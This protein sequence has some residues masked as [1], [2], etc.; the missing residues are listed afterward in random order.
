MTQPTNR[1]FRLPGAL[2]R[3][4]DATAGNPKKAVESL[5]KTVG[6]GFGSVPAAPIDTTKDLPPVP[7][8]TA[9]Q[10][11]TLMMAELNAAVRSLVESSTELAGRLGR[12]GAINSILES[13]AGVFPASGVLTRTYEVAAGSIAIENLSATHTLIVTTGVAAGDTGANTAGVG[14]SYVR[15]NSLGRSPLADHSF[16]ITGT[17]GDSISFEVFTGL[18]AYGVDTP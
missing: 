6:G 2:G 8:L 14:V 7:K 4:Q 10:A 1:G 18:Q 13:W 12:R 9:S 11:Q 3:A 5:P 16:T 17:A 15:A